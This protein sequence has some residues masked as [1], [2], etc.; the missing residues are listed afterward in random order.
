MRPKISTTADPMKG[1]KIYLVDRVVT[2]P[3]SAKA[4]VEAYL[5]E[6]APGGHG[7]SMTLDRVLVSPPMW[8]EEDSNTIT[9]TWTLDSVDS[10]WKQIR[11][12]RVDRS[13]GEWW[14]HMNP[15]I[16]ERSRSMSAAATDIE[17]LSNV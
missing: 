4:F 2:T 1:Q 10:V 12:S 6:Y 9:I 13:L 3:G 7:R 5:A 11:A 16:V 17:G 15:L 8:L 14:T